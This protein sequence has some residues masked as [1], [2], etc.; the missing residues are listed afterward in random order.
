VTPEQHL[1]LAK[2]LYW[3]AILLVLGAGLFI[4]TGCGGGGGSSDP[5][6]RHLSLIGYGRSNDWH[7]PSDEFPTQQSFVRALSAHG[8]TWTGIEYS[9]VFQPQDGPCETS[10]GG[11]PGTHTYPLEFATLLRE[12]RHENLAV[13]V[14]VA[15][16]NRCALRDH[17]SDQWIANA[18]QEIIQ[19]AEGRFDDLYVSPI[20]E[21]SDNNPK[22]SRRWFDLSEKML[23]EAGA[24]RIVAPQA[25]CEARHALCDHH[26]QS[27]GDIERWIKTGNSRL[28]VNTDG[29]NTFELGPVRAGWATSLA[30]THGTPFSVYAWRY[31]G[32]HLPIIA[33]MAAK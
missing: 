5:A 17:A 31:R 18:T 7:L 1:I 6:P 10:H 14:N 8:L 3:M 30:V 29:T 9:P 26:P 22:K 33:A 21:P 11:R 4:V 28:L 16:M 12:A 23:R 27:D 25:W 2:R 19:A 15:N 20:C 32:P 24:A 13:L